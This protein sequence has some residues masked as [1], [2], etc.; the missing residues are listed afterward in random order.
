MVLEKTFPPDE[1]V[2]NEINIL[3]KQGFYI[4]LICYGTSKSIEVEELKNLKIYRFPI[5]RLMYKLSALALLLPS[6]FWFWKKNIITVME[7]NV[8]AAIHVHDLPL[9]KVCISIANRYRIPVVG[10]YHENRPE[11]MKLY[12]HTQNFPGNVLISIKKWLEYQLKYTRLLDRLIL[13]T[14]EAKIYYVK[15]YKVDESKITVLPNYVVLERINQFSVCEDNFATDLRN[16]FTIV[17]FGDT[18]L[19]RGTMTII[20]AAAKLLSNSNI[21]FLILGNSKEQEILEEAVNKLRLNNV[22]LTG[23]IPVAEAMKYISISKVGLCPFLRN[24]HH[25]TTYANKMFQYMALGKPVIASDCVS[26]ANLIKRE[27]CGL[28]YAAG[29]SDELS[30]A[31]LELFIHKDK[32]DEHKKRAKDCVNLYYNWETSGRNLTELYTNL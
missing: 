29:D 12:N 20:E 8:I 22:T 7:Q 24:I 17:Y 18:G 23:W 28:V 4:I 19:R 27:E 30:N 15:N 16:K 32:Y 6:Y 5:S 13:V 1:R 11:I 31:I 26:Q 10:D 21:H 2:E 25:D 9:V 14:E 3:T